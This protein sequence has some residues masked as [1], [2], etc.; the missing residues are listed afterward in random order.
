M[1]EPTSFTYGLHALLRKRSVELGLAREHLAQARTHV[2][3]RTLELE[4][5]STRLV[6]L[7]SEQRN[8]SKHGAVIDVDAR[9]RL[10]ACLTEA[11]S[12]EQQQAAQLENATALQESALDALRVARQE[13]KAIERHR[14]QAA[15]QFDTQQRRKTQLETDELYLCNARA[16][17]LAAIPTESAD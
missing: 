9:M 1:T 17:A 16:K 13:L 12:T 2:E 7:E 10:H 8:L 6:Q 3:A 14:E 15:A 4:L 11:R 5:S